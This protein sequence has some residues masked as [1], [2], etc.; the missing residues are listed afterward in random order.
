MAEM[1]SLT[2]NG[3]RYI[4]KDAGSAR[5]DEEQ[6]ISKEQKAQARK[7]IGVKDMLIVTV[8]DNMAS[9][10]AAEIYTHVQNGGT[11]VC[12]NG[13]SC[14]NLSYA[15]GSY[16]LFSFVEDDAHVYGVKV[17]VDGTCENIEFSLADA[18]S[19]LPAV[20]A[21]D[22]GKFLQVTDGVWA[23]ADA[24]P[25]MQALMDFYIREKFPAMTQAEYD[26]LGDGEDRAKYY[27]IL[28]ENL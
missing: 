14:Y 8:E 19:V 4:T 22:S 17:L 27:T 3:I 7:N 24:V 21:E 12:V 1:K 6:N 16:A 28:E 18:I 26:A 9:R 25:Q 10:T 5:F 15:E 20:T 11:A 23:A 2:I 13:A